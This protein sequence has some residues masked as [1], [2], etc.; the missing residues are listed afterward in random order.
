MD[1]HQFLISSSSSQL[2]PGSGILK[3]SHAV[4]QLSSVPN[5]PGRMPSM[6]G[7]AL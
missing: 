1:F 7:C 6:I 2:Y 4:Q 3:I 5:H